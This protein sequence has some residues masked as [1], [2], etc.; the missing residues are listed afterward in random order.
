MQTNIYYYASTHG[1]TFTHS[2][3]HKILLLTDNGI[4]HARGGIATSVS[5]KSNG[6]PQ[7]AID[8]KADGDFMHGSCTH[9]AEEYEPSW[10]VYFTKQ[11]AVREVVITNRADCCGK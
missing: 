5:V 8:G 10:Q 7:K 3:I 9:T 1:R 4:N 11:I 2:Y 6:H